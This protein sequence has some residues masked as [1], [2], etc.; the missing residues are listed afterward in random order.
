MAAGK[1]HVGPLTVYAAHPFVD[2][3]V[4]QVSGS[5]C[6]DDRTL[7]LALT[8]GCLSRVGLAMLYSSAALDGLSDEARQTFLS[9][10]IY[11]FNR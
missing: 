8:Q 10:R 4:Y 1:S 7:G 9:S 5:R 3:H 6:D 11:Y 2:D